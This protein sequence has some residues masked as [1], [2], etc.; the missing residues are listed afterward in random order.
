MGKGS[1]GE[2][3]IGETERNMEKR[4]SEHNNPREKCEPE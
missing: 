2:E 1:C 3:Y 4:W